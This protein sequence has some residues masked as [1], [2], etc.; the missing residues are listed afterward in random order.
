MAILTKT[1]RGDSKSQP[2][3]LRT[4]INY[5]GSTQLYVGPLPNASRVYLKPSLRMSNSSLRKCKK[6]RRIWEAVYTKWCLLHEEF[7]RKNIVQNDDYIAEE[8]ESFQRS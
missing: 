2:N 6:K 1:Q 3:M 8:S 7:R 5:Y 4:P